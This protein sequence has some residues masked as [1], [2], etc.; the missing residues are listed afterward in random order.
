MNDT[1]TNETVALLQQLIRNKCVNDGDVA[2]GHEVRT[3][4]TLRAYL[5]GSGLDLEVYE[6]D[7]APGRARRTASCGASSW[8]P[9]PVSHRPSAPPT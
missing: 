9:C 7:G 2:S 3:S 5:Q 6:P 8:R 4:D 1:L